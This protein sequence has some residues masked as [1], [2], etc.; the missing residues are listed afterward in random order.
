MV[1]VLAFNHSSVVSWGFAA[2][3]VL[4]G[5]VLAVGVG[6]S[7]GALFENAQQVGAWMLVP[8]VVLMAPIMLAM[9]GNLPPWLEALLP[10]LPTVALAELFLFSFSGGTALASVLSRTALIAGW[11]LPLY[12][13]VIWMVRRSNR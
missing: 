7:L 9:L 6:L 13:A 2:L 12:A 1:V 10:W 4:I 8:I 11:S 3:A 5:S